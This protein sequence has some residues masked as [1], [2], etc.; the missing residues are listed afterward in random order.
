MTKGKSSKLDGGTRVI[1]TEFTNSAGTVFKIQGLPPLLMPQL[2]A[3]IEQPKKP[4]YEVIT[5]SGDVEIHEHDPKSLSTPEELAAWQEYIADL[6]KVEQELSERLLNC[7]LIEGVSIPEDV[8]MVRWI[9]RQKLMGLEVPD[10][11]EERLLMYKRSLVIRSSEDL[12]KLINAVMSLTGIN[13]EEI[14]KAKSSFPDIV[15]PDA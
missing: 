4:T 9:K 15:E 5:A 12:P 3:G 1:P 6:R 8:D 7:I 14:E 10:D 11:E 13:Q 2:A